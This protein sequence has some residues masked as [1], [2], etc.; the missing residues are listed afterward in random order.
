VDFRFFNVEK[1]GEA[2]DRR[3]TRT[4]HF[5]SN[6]WFL[7]KLTT[8]PFACVEAII[9]DSKVERQLGRFVAKT[10]PAEVKQF[11]MLSQFI[12]HHKGHRDHYHVR[13]GEL[14]GVLGCGKK[15]LD[16]EMYAEFASDEEAVDSV[17]AEASAD[18][19]EE[20]AV[21]DKDG[22]RA[23]AIA[24]EGVV[25]TVRGQ[26]GTAS[27]GTSAATI[28]GT[29]IVPLYKQEPQITQDFL[30]GERK[31]APRRHRG[32]KRRHARR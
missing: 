29:E 18:D 16:P 14:P 7:K 10:Y 13:F 12:V 1:Q 8:N 31:S 22:G 26:R 17:L 4:Y 21:L 24:A 9:L 3:F 15:T 30:R 11:E 28:A 6:W 23:S 27:D 2:I 32:T 5:A 19:A 20:D 25:A